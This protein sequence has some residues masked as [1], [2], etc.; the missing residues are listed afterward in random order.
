MLLKDKTLSNYG[1]GWEV[2]APVAQVGKI[3]WHSGDNPGYK[4]EIMRYIGKDRTLI[5]LCNNA[6][7]NFSELIKELQPIMKN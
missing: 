3:V 7:D 6:A 2:I 4:T 5:I 1:F